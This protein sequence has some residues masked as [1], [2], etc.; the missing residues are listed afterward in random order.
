MVEKRGKR[1]RIDRIKMMEL[2]D[3]GMGVSAIARELGCTKG[4]ISK[5]LKTM[6]V[7]V[8][9][10]NTRVAARYVQK[11]NTAADHLLHLAD[12]LRKE[13][14]FMEK[15]IPAK[16]TKDY[17]TWQDQKIKVAAEM[18]KLIKEMGDIG[19]KLFQAQHVE[20]MLAIIVEEIGLESRT[21]QRRIIERI[22]TQQDIC[23]TIESTGGE[24]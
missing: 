21:C 8:V 3:R 17:Q 18:R 15:E 16:V 10:A 20:D 13:L 12:E 22:S 11:K 2:Y 14:D 23:L 9:A 19:Y 6:G 7:Q 5:I 4:A 1:P 24:S